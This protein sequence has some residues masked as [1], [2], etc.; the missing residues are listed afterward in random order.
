MLTHNETIYPGAFVAHPIK[1][2][3]PEEE[4]L[5]LNQTFC[6]FSPLGLYNIPSYYQWFL[7]T[8]KT[9]GYRMMANLMRLISWSRGESESKRWILKNPQHMLDLDIL[10]STFPDAKI[11]FTHRDPLKTV[12]SVMSLMWFYAVQHTDMPCRERIKDVWLDFCEQ[13]ARRCIEMRTTI[14]S[15]QQF[16]IYYEE[17]N[18]DWQMSMRKLY[19]FANI[20]FTSEVEQAMATWLAKSA[21]E[22]RHGSH[23]YSL[24]DFG[25]SREEVDS[26]MMFVREK[27]AV[28]YEGKQAERGTQ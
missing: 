14:P 13:A 23:H 21:D 3:W 8:D 24:E 26:R 1:A 15:S 28:P 27:Y 4:M 19:T 10:L 17:M 2:D 11:I 7:N 20:E 25:T 9:F 22:K 16:D 5:L 6:G 12:G 18:R